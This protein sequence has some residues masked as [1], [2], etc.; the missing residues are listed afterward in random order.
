MLLHGPTARTGCTSEDVE[1]LIETLAEQFPTEPCVKAA[2]DR[3]LRLRAGPDYTNMTLGEVEEKLRRFLEKRI[4]TDFSIR[5]LKP[6]TG[7]ISKE[8]FDFTLECADRDPPVERLVLR[9]QAPQS[10]AETHRAREYELMRALQGHLPV[11]EQRWIDADGEEF[12]NPALICSFLPG[13][14]RPP[15]S[16]PTDV[17]M[18]YGPEYREKL[19]P[20]FVDMLGKVAAI[21]VAKLDLKTFVVPPADSA[22]GLVQ[23]INWWA[24]VWREDALEPDPLVTLTEHWLRANAPLIDRPS[25]THGDYRAGNFLFDPVTAE[26]TALL[27]WELAWIGDRHLDLAYALQPLFIE[28]DG[29]RDY[30]CGLM[31]RDAFLK[32]YEEASGLPVDRD[33]LTY[34][35]VFVSWRNIVTTIA[36]GGRCAVSRKTHQDVSFAWFVGT[37]APSAMSTMR[38]TL[39]IAMDRLPEN[40]NL[41]EE[42]LPTC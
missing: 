4:G 27:D 37:I 8:Q 3:K 30:H 18:F 9:T 13:V 1:A 11:P 36:G 29:G 15:S 34:Y 41:H 23:H 14:V 17:R 32:R 21:D 31:E 6:L 39:Q 28:S 26:I 12:D 22:E 2:L 16:G 25:L 19:G 7:G 42:S 40:S 33:R 20:Q 24:R 38:R 35:E 5:G 10:A